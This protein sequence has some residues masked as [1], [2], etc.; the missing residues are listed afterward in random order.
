MDNSVTDQAP[1]VQDAVP[2]GSGPIPSAQLLEEINS[3]PRMTSQEA[4]QLVE[5]YGE[6]PLMIVTMDRDSDGK[7]DTGSDSFLHKVGGSDELFGSGDAAQLQSV[8]DNS[9]SNLDQLSAFL[10]SNYTN[11]I[12]R[13]DGNSFAF[14]SDSRVGDGV[15]GPADF[16]RIIDTPAATQ[17]FSD[18]ND[19]FDTFDNQSTWERVVGSGAIN[20][21]GLQNIDVSTLTPEEQDAVKY[22]QDNFSVFDNANP[23]ADGYIDMEDIERVRVELRPKTYGGNEEYHDGQQV[24]TNEVIADATEQYDVKRNAEIQAAQTQVMN[25]RPVTFSPDEVSF[26]V[27]S[28][29]TLY[30][31]V[32]TE[33]RA[34]NAL[35]G[36][37]VMEE[38]PPGADIYN[39]PLTHDIAQ[40]NDI[41]DYDLIFPDQPVVI[42]KA[43]LDKYIDGPAQSFGPR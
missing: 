35:A 30:D 27:Q 7:V 25:D 34:I 11:E 31:L 32:N 9:D 12:D 42:N 29:D 6:V 3:I 17:Q 19:V 40:A 23:I 5:K 41:T 43:I 22:L 36:R 2:M 28:G 21:D 39:H 38:V 1:P 26:K 20:R 18:V 10:F 4:Q 13:F 37:T 14:N 16:Q 15:I 8:K 24:D 33:I